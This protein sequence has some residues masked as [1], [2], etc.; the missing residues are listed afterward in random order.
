MAKKHAGSPLTTLSH[1]LDL[2]WMREAY[3]RVRRDSAPGVDGQTVAGYGENLDAN[4]T[5]LLDRAKSGTYRAPLVKRVHIPK[6]ETETRPIGMPTVENKVLER[7]VAMLLEPVY[8][9][10]FLDCSF[11]FRPGR[12]PHQALDA[13]RAAV[14]AM[15][16]GW[17]L[18]V[19]VRKY[20]DTIPHQQLRDVLSLRIRDGVISRLVGKWLKAG[21]WEAGQVTYPEAGTPQGGVMTPW[22]HLVILSI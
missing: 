5:S 22:T 11:G 8:E 2:L 10:E 18:D 19:D 13:V 17:V 16:G 21:I 12:S 15:G 1:Q 6:S 3:G 14:M 9:Q 7:A 20:F 4:L